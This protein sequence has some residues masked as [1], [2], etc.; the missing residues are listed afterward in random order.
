MVPL[1]LFQPGVL[2]SS[3][4]K[5]QTLTQ[6]FIKSSKLDIHKTC[7]PHPA[8]GIGSDVINYILYIL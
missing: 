6:Q 4:A 2:G 7:F 1:G 8:L 5:D 3:F